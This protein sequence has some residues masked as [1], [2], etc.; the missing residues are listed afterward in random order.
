MKKGFKRLAVF[1]SGSGTNFEAI[2]RSILK[3][4]IN[5]RIVLVISNNPDA[6]AIEKSKKFCIDCYVVSEKDFTDH[7]KYVER[8]LELLRKYNIDFILLAGYLKKVPSEI[9]QEYRWRILNIHPALLPKF[10]G[11]GMYGLNV[12]RAVLEAGEKVT[13]VTI[14]F[15]DEEYDHGPIIIQ[16]K[17]KVKKDDTPESLQKRVL[18]IEHKLYPYVV[19][20]LCKGK[21]KLPVR[22]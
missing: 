5:G 16:K 13:G 17:V 11:K 2:Q 22:S 1:V 3:G 18:K 8:I 20:R 7:V 19:S 15:V 10:G 14:H 21:I 12:H 6:G 4:K 9:V